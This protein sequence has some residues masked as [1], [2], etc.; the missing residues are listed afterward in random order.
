[1]PYGLIFSDL[2]TNNQNNSRVHSQP[3]MINLINPTLAN[4]YEMSLQS[5]CDEFAAYFRDKIAN[6]WPCIS[7]S[8]PDEKFDNMCPSLS[9]K[10]TMELFSLI[11]TDILRKVISQLK[12]ST[13]LLNP[14]TTTCFKISF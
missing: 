1:M 7:Q 11:D 5:K 12:P 9:G 8:R 2:I 14:N 13:C 4:L 6:T 3:L 10:G